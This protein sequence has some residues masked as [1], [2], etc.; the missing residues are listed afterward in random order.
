MRRESQV[1]QRTPLGK[2]FYLEITEE[3]CEF[4]ANG[5]L[6]EQLIEHAKSMLVLSKSTWTGDR[7]PPPSREEGR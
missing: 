1:I 7:Y 6:S 4:I 5:C 3:E 2:R